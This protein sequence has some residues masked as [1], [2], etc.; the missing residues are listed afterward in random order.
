MLVDIHRRTMKKSPPETGIAKAIAIAGSQ[1]KLA[2][3]IGANQ[4]MVSYWNKAGIV[5]DTGMCAAIERETGF[6][7]EE[8]NRNEDCATLLLVLCAP[9]RVNFAASDDTQP[10][11]GG[12]SDNS[13]LSR[14]VA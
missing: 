7:C 4:Q 8:L 9:D 14:M 6:R 13:N 10:P 5:S 11:V 2:A 12:S 3:L 1:V